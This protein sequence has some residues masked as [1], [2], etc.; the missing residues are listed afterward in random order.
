MRVSVHTSSL[1]PC[2]SVSGED[3]LREEESPLAVPT[4]RI[5]KAAFD[6]KRPIIVKRFFMSRSSVTKNDL[7]SV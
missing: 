6:T 7:N 2:S 5:S 1:V 4:M 3:P